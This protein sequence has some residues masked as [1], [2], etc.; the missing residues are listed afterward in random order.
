MPNILEF[1]IKLRDQFTSGLMGMSSNVNKQFERMNRATRPVIRSLNDIQTQM[2]ECERTIK[3]SVDTSQIDAASADLKRLRFEEHSFKQR[4]GM[5]ASPKGSSGMGGLLSMGSIAGRI[6]QLIAASAVVGFGKD[7]F[8]EAINYSRQKKAIDF[9]TGGKSGDAINEIE[10]I[11]EK[12]GINYKAGVTGFKTLSGSLRGMQLQK[13]MDIFKGVSAGV[14]A[15]GLSAEDAQGTFLALGQIASKGT[16][17]A[18]ELRGQI[19]ERIP[20]AFSIAAQAMGVTE[21]Q[22]GKMMEKGELAS[23]VFLPKFA[24]QLNKTFGSAAMS[25][26]NGP[27][28]QME[29][30]A[31]SMFKL[32]V[33]I[34]EEL[35]PVLVPFIQKYLIPATNWLVK[36]GEAIGTVIRG[37]TKLMSI[38]SIGVFDMLDRNAAKAMEA[39][40]SNFRRGV[41]TM[42]DAIKKGVTDSELYDFFANAG[43]LHGV[44]YQE[45]LMG[46][47]RSAATWADKFYNTNFFTQKLGDIMASKKK[48]AVIYANPGKKNLSSTEEDSKVKDL[49]KNVDTITGG[50]AKNVY[51]SLGKFQD[52]LIIKTT[53]IKEG[54]NEMED[55]IERSLLRLLNSA[56]TITQ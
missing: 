42:K 43:K 38:A 37:F 35:I 7:S 12:L 4:F 56:N 15:M 31:N 26:S 32:R 52:Q 8:D 53:T 51:I 50:G 23:S 1:T 45:A 36:H 29:R 22:L 6:P 25:N 5:V 2:R 48:G 24:N 55:M 3:M 27:A 17:S 30:L 33:V 19:G 21:K 10:K 11:S 20:G 39:N 54:L 28:A 9:G 49:A 16:V 18:E 41:H 34:G 40:G 47:I 44:A 14:A 13:Q 46:G